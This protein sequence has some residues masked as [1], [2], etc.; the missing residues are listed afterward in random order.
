MA[1]KFKVEEGKKY[2]LVPDPH[3]D[4]FFGCKMCDLRDACF[5]SS[6]LCDEMG[7]SDCHFE[8]AGEANAIIDV[9]ELIIEGTNSD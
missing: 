5:P 6:L 8:L 9:D 3:N 1:E 2:V 7:R 4:S